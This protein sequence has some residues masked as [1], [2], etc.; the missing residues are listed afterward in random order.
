MRRNWRYC[1]R[2]FGRL[3]CMEPIIRTCPCVSHRQNGCKTGVRKRGTIVDCSK[4]DSSASISNN[5]AL[6]TESLM[7]KLLF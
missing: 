3:Q 7:N 2:I 5:E 4:C 6:E 1:F